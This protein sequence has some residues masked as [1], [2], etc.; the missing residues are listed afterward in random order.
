M[1]V[2]RSVCGRRW[3]L[4]AD[5]DAAAERLAERLDLPEILAQLLVRRGL[6]GDRAPGF[7]APRLRDH[8]PEPLSLRDMDRAAARLVAAITRGERIAVFGDYDVDGATS[9]ALLL[10]FLA[11]VGAPARVYVPDRLAEGY[12]PNAPALLRLQA[13]G[14]RVVVAVDCGTTAHDA[15]AAAQAAGL[16]VIVVDHHV[17]E[18]LLPPAAAVVNPN[19]LDEDG[20]HG[21][22]AAVG[23]AFLLVVALNR[24]LR[25]AGWYRRDRVEPDL[26]SWLDLVALGTVCDVVPLTG[27]NRAFVAQGLK[28]A[29]RG[30]N[31]GLAALARVAGVKTPLDAYHLGFVLGPR[32]NAG[33]R[34]GGAD[35]GARL[36]ATDDP[37]LA[38]ELAARLDGYNRERRAIEAHTLEAAIAVVEATPQSPVLAFAAAPDWHPGVIGIVAA[39]LKERYQR[40][41]CVVAVAGGIGRG[42]GRSIPG[43]ALG[44]AVVAARQAGLLING[45]GH[46]MAAGFTVA[47]DRI[48][49][50]RLYLV[51]RLGDGL[52]RD[53]LVPEL[54][55]DGLFSVGAATAE[56]VRQ[57]EA[58]AP[59]G[60]ANP[61]PRF[62]FAPV[63]VLYPEPVGD[64]HLR[65]TLADPLGPARVRAIAFRA[66]ATPLGR[67]LAETRGT[68]I[69]VAGHLRRDSWRGG[70]A[71]ALTIDDA[72]PA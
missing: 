37:D 27:L 62:A 66:A 41:A 7:L 43:V 63:R 68:A 16:D 22:L 49:T 47:A 21:T 25:A 33:G 69:Q 28:I 64:G 52:D 54:S 42:S 70:D 10:R 36:L 4:H 15:L 30:R 2:E 45:G 67:F 39:R 17:A 29:H 72:A 20:R 57:I 59:F 65:C 40:P 32:V 12:G 35:L 60:A 71:V 53:S 31:P 11:A 18:P 8:L 34:V 24:A 46:A 44:P 5:E 19:R 51:E 3:R 26:L 1:I 58:M 56:L 13:E 38:T 23:L 50:L 55:L 9:A 14:A 48:E 61:E 6:D